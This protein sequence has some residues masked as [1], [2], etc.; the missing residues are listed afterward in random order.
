MATYFIGDIHLPTERTA[1]TALLEQFLRRIGGKAEALYILGDLFEVWVG[2][3][4]SPQ[5][6]QAITQAIRHTVQ[7]HTPVY[8]MHGNRDFLVGERFAH[9]AGCQLI[10]DPLV[11][12]LYGHR[13]LL[14]HGDA[15][16]T[17]DIAYQ[18]FRKEVREPLWQQKFLSMTPAEREATAA[19]YRTESKRYTAEKPSE[20]MDVNQ[21]AVREVM[22]QYH[23]TRMIHGHTHRPA[24]H[25]FFIDELP[26]QRYVIGDWHSTGSALRCDAKIWALEVIV[27]E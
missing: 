5:H 10:H 9:A 27:P 17:D 24:V 4:V 20:I 15:L 1:V 8:L 23:V 13:T 21:Q 19:N 16:C 25:D 7:Q 11:I 6:Y 22:K 26:A 18:R 2:D 14:T 3:D 12:N